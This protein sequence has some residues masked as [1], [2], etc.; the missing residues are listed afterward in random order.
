MVSISA[1]FAFAVNSQF[2]CL[3]FN[4]FVFDFAGNFWKSR[5]A[6]GC[7]ELQTVVFS[8]IVTRRDVDGAIQ[9]LTD[10]RECDAGVGTACEHSLA[11]IFCDDNTRATSRPKFSEANR[12]S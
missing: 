5:S 6:I 4:D 11:R 1:S 3:Q 9:L 2:A 12:V 8:R 10:H 7:R